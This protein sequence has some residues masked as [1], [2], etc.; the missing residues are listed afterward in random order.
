M[1]L[2]NS[3]SFFKK[4]NIELEYNPAN[5]LLGIYSRELK[6]YKDLDTNVHSSTR[7]SRRITVT[8]DKPQ[9]MVQ[10]NDGTLFGRAKKCYHMDE[11]TL[12]TC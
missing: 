6:T 2:G 7:T 12:K 3:L 9:N 5:P 11:G 1:A 4:L 8:A 10:P